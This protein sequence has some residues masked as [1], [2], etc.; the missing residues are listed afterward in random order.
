MLLG[1]SVAQHHIITAAFVVASHGCAL[2]TPHT[3]LAICLTLSLLTARCAAIPRY[4]RCICVSGPVPCRAASLTTSPSLVQPSHISSSSSRAL[5]IRSLSRCWGVGGVSTGHTLSELRDGFACPPR[6]PG[7]ARRSMPPYAYAYARHACSSVSRTAP[8]SVRL[9]L[10]IY[11]PSRPS[12]QAYRLWT[13]HDHL[14]WSS[15]Y[16]RTPSLADAPVCA[17]AKPGWRH[18]ARC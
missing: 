3:T 2:S 16:P 7:S 8:S 9:P 14:S 15:R 17:Y 13:D 6:T 5:S 10:S 4:S 1:R 18:S 11:P 12:T